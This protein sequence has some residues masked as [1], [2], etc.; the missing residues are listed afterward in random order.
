VFDDDNIVIHHRHD[1]PFQLG[2]SNLT[3]RDWTH[4]GANKFVVEPEAGTM[5]STE[6]VVASAETI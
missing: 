3:L 6:P 1:Y 2:D 5:A 4:R